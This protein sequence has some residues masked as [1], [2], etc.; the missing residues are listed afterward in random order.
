MLITII[1]INAITTNSPLIMVKVTN[2]IQITY[3]T[4]EFIKFIIIIHQQSF[5][6]YSCLRINLEKFMVI[7]IH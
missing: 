5:M 4:K 7:N 1:N 2:Q 6:N 3:K